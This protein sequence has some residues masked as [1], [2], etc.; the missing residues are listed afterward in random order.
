MLYGTHTLRE[1]KKKKTG[2]RVGER[3][4]KAPNPLQ[5]QQENVLIH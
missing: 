5:E 2:K 4:K 1:I 3:I